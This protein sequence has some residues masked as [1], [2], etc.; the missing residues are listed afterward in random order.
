MKKELFIYSGAALVA[1][2][3]FKPTKQMLAQKELLFDFLSVPGMEDIKT[4]AYDDGVGNQ[5]IGVGHVIK[6]YEASLLT[7]KLT[8]PEIKAL[9]DAD[10][11]KAFSIVD[12][13]ITIRLTDNQRVACASFAFNTNTMG[14][15]L[16][17]AINN[18][19]GESAI[20]KAWGEWIYATDAKTKEKI[21]LNGLINRRKKELD[22]FFS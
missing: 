1:W 16:A 3:L 11:N 2:L 15:M 17:Q 18:R 21:I 22:L 13:S 12:R 20:R 7:K 14:N 8:M 6:N 5:T 19:L 10:S 4:H 9:F